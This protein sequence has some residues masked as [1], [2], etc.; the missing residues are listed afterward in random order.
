M[1]WVTINPD[2]AAFPSLRRCAN[3]LLVQAV[4]T[5]PSEVDME[6]T[7]SG[8]HGTHLPIAEALW[9]LAGIILLIAFGDALVLLVLAFAVVAM[10]TAWWIYRKVEQRAGRN[11]AV[12]APVTHLRPAWTG[13]RDRKETSAHASWRGPSAAA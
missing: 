1:K 9:I 12:L 10:T 2:W 11:D 7:S 13:H 4:K 3:R 8:Q 6:T 5:T